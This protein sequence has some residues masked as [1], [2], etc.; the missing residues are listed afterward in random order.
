MALRQD[1]PKHLFFVVWIELS[2]GVSFTKHQDLVITGTTAIGSLVF[3]HDNARNDV[4]PQ[5]FTGRIE[6]CYL[7]PPLSTQL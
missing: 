5:D 7:D 6:T 4:L 1:I 2:I 3:Y